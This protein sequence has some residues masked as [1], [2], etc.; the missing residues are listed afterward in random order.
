MS[1]LLYVNHKPMLL[2]TSLRSS[3]DLAAQ[4]SSAKCRNV[5]DYLQALNIQANM[6]EQVV[7]VFCLKAMYKKLKAHAYKAGIADYLCGIF[8]WG[9]L[10]LEGGHAAALR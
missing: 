1:S 6:I 8:F 9:R 3:A 7:K 10:H 5:R 4:G 2:R